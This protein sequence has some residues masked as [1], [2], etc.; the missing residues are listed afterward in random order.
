MPVKGIRV[1]VSIADGGQ[2][3]YAEE[4]GVGKRSRRQ[5]SDASPSEQ[6]KRCEAEVNE[7]VYPEDQAGKLWPAKGQD[8]VVNIAPVV[9]RSVD[10]DKL[11]VSGLDRDWG[12]RSF[13]EVAPLSIQCHG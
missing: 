10:F 12:R 6:I 11:A 13:H 8:E 5:F 9:F 7:D 1:G 3:F 2:R 4:E